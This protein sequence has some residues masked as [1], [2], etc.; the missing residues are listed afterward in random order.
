MQNE[1]N[2]DYKKK[3]IELEQ[4]KQSGRLFNEIIKT[5]PELI[6]E[7]NMED[8]ENL[9]IYYELLFKKYNL[10]LENINEILK[11]SS[12]DQFCNL[13]KEENFKIYN[14]IKNNIKYNDVFNLEEFQWLEYDIKDKDF[15]SYIRKKSLIYNN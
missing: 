6:S 2:L 8:F 9:N 4:V 12:Q 13:T 10:E 15:D 14:H 5:S 1:K 7:R 11:M 3:I